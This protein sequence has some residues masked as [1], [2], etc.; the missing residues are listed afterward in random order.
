MYV[1]YVLDLGEQLPLVA[2]GAA[3]REAL[4][5]LVAVLAPVQVQL[6]ETVATRPIKTQNHSQIQ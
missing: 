1:T 3:A 5:A 6:E 2:V 4:G